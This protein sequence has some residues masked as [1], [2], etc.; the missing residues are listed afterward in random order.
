MRTVA[1]L[2]HLEFVVGEHSQDLIRRG[3]SLADQ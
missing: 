1:R 2:Q 3:A